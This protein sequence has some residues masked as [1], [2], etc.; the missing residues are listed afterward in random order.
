VAAVQASMTS[1]HLP[2]RLV[3]RLSYGA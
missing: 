3:E 1:L 2:Q